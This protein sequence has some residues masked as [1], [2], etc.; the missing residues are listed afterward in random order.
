MA[1]I[2]SGVEIAAASFARVLLL[3]ISVYVFLYVRDGPGRM[4]VPQSFRRIRLLFWAAV[5][6]G[7]LRVRRFLFSVSNAGRF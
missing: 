2:Y 5:L 1:L 3:G 6:S 7:A 4:E